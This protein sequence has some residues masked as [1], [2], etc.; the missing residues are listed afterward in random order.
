MVVVADVELAGGVGRYHVG[1]RIGHR[2]NG[3]LQVGRLEIC[4]AVV[5][6]GRTQPV[7][8]ADHF[9]DR[10]VGDMGIGGVALAAVHDELGVERSAPADFDFIAERARV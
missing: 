1:R 7:E 2:N 4:R 5:E 6:L 10:V 9:R 3:H 8:N